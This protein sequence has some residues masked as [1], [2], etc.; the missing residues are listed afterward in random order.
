MGWD[1]D[2]H[3]GLASKIAQFVCDESEAKTSLL[4]KFHEDGL[5]E[6]GFLVDGE[7]FRQLLGCGIDLF[8]NGNGCKYSVP[9]SDQ[10][11]SQDIGGERPD[12]IKQ[13][14]K[15][16]DSQSRKIKFLMKNGKGDRGHQGAE[17]VI[18]GIEDETQDDEGDPERQDDQHT[19]NDLCPKM[20]EDF[21]HVDSLYRRLKDPLQIRLLDDLLLKEEAGQFFQFIFL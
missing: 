1:E 4:W 3:L 8:H 19:C 17:N 2:D 14:K 10:L 9:P 18:Q 21:F 5:A 13:K 11:A 20:F 15:T 7:G 16:D 12:Q 6:R